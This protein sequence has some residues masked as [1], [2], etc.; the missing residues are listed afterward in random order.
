MQWLSS[1]LG[2][3]AL[4]LPGLI[5]MLLKLEEKAF[6]LHVHMDD[7]SFHLVSAFDHASADS[8]SGRTTGFPSRTE[9]NDPQLNWLCRKVSCTGAYFVG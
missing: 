5:A 8:G 2:Y 3:M 6:Y 1:E 7:I 4:V 9:K